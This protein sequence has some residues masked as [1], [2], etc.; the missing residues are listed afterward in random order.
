[1]NPKKKLQ[2]LGGLSPEEFMHV[3]WQKKPLLIRQAI[4]NFKPPM[5]RLA[6]FD[7]A[8][9]PETETRLVSHT[10][11]KEASTWRM[12]S[13]P[14]SRR[15]LPAIKQ[16]NWTLLVQG[17]DL[18][19]TEAHKLLNEF[20]FVPD[21]R[22]DDLMVSYASKGGGVGPHFDSYDVFLLQGQGRRRWQISQQKNL[23]LRKDV[24]LKILTHFVPENE[25]ILEQ[26]DMLYLPPQ[27]AHD[28][29]SLDNACLTYSIG[30]RSPTNTEISQALLSRL[31]D[32]ES[33]EVEETLYQDRSQG[34]F[35]TPGRL[36]PALVDFTQQSIH[37][38]IGSKQNVSRVLG[39]YMTEPKPFVWFNPVPNPKMRKQVVLDRKT[40]MMYDERH[41]FING[42]SF[43]TSGLDARLIRK[44]ADQR[45]LLIVEF[46][47]LS[48]Q[49][50]L[51]VKTWF[52]AGWIYAE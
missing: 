38:K 31:A 19:N 25:F 10:I 7:L 1:M 14:F 22:L 20:R 49:A 3:Y 5:D 36:P 11:Q 8:C 4:K 17:V 46:N 45:M 35:A 47:K 26:G 50:S 34:A 21:A 43:R 52:Q 33:T 41:V 24:P 30:F 6:L 48:P 51:L 27:V 37:K 15:A 12:R 18:Y 23:A 42:E 32:D 39:E 44:L 2:L 29:V 9:S 13:G 28:G 40:K 16:Q